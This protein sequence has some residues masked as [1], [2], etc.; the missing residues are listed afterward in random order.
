LLQFLVQTL[1]FPRQIPEIAQSCLKLSLK[2]IESIPKKFFSL[3][4]GG[5]GGMTFAKGGIFLGQNVTQLAA[6]LFVTPDLQ[7]EMVKRLLQL[8]MTMFHI[9]WDRHE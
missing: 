4:E 2:I 1:I 5:S 7:L 8:L 3:P 9:N 6:M